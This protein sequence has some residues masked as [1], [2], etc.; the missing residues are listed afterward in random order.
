MTLKLL[1]CATLSTP[2]PTTTFTNLRKFSKPIKK[3]SWMIRLFVCTLKIC[4][5]AYEHRCCRSCYD[6]IDTS[7]FLSWLRYVVATNN[8]GYHNRCSS[9]SHHSDL[10]THTHGY[11]MESLR[12]IITHTHTPTRT[13]AHTHVHTHTQAHTC[14]GAEH[15]RT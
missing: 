15:T 4:C 11:K 2:S 9:G 6:R 7:H 8:S 3:P 12:V 1:R 10:L 14:T 5:V 13:H